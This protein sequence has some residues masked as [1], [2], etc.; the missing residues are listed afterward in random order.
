M[1]FDFTQFNLDC[2]RMVIYIDDEWIP[3]SEPNEV[4]DILKEVFNGDENIAYRACYYCTQIPLAN[5]YIQEVM[6]MR[7]IHLN[8]HLLSHTSHVVTIYSSSKTMKIK[9]DF[10]QSYIYEGEEYQLDYCTL[11]F[12]Y[13]PFE[14]IEYNKKWKY[15]IQNM[16]DTDKRYIFDSSYS[17]F[18]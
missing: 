14:N 12:S 1:N 7:M 3:S 9:K 18:V 4:W 17:N 10:I 5:H 13:N 15:T 8:E 2:P 6:D 11:E 16:R